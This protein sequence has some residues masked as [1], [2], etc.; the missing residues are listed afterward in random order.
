MTEPTTKPP[1]QPEQEKGP[2]M[3]QMMLRS[4]DPRNQA[5]AYETASR[6]E[7]HKILAGAAKQI[8]SMSWGQNLSEH[9][10]FAIARW[11][12][13]AGI[14]P[15]RH[16]DILGNRIY[17]N[18]QFYLDGI[19]SLAD[20]VRDE[21][22]IIAP[23]D[24]RKIDPAVVG[25]ER[26]KKLLA[27]QRAINARRLALQ[28]QYEVPPDI[29]NFPTDA[30]AVVVRLY[31]A[32]QAE[33]SVGVNWAG[34]RGRTKGQRGGAYDPIGDQEPVKTAH[35]RALRKAAMKRIPVWFKQGD[36]EARFAKAEAAI[37]SDREQLKTMG[38]DPDE[39]R[40]QVE[41]GTKLFQRAMQG[42]MD[43]AFFG[44]TSRGA[45]LKN[46]EDPYAAETAGESEAG[47]TSEQR[48]E[49]ADVELDETPTP[50]PVPPEPLPTADA[51]RVRYYLELLSEHEP[52]FKKEQFIAAA[53]FVNS[54]G[55][56][57]DALEARIAD[58][59]TMILDAS[60]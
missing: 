42:D 29:N 3:T 19:A 45:P 13:E 5:L 38:L 55:C 34:S 21:W 48:I 41:G 59:E 40:P 39:P 37:A 58:V 14:D 57:P 10:T 17:V 7:R 22:E 49:E 30:A 50:V 54:A 43:R 15:A 52:L 18:A 2:S 32:G 12:L 26:A 33:P 27:E 44:G 1:E 8:A 20:F 35:T 47:E 24:T 16:I 9:S 36:L 53:K 46:P 51:A 31:F 60:R 11:A 56:T 6:I 28:M 25:E 23:L 4:E